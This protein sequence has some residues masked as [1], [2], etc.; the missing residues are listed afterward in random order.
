MFSHINYII[1]N[2]IGDAKFKR[3]PRYTIHNNLQPSP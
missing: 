2:K 1:H 3:Y